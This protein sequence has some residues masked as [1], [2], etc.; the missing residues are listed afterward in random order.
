MLMNRLTT[1]KQGT[2]VDPGGPRRS[3]QAQATSSQQRIGAGLIAAGLSTVLLL[4]PGA[5]A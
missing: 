3:V 5:G 2:R 4:G 1:V